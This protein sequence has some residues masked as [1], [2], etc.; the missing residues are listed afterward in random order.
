MPSE[1]ILVDERLGQLQTHLH[2]H[3]PRPAWWGLRCG[4]CRERWVRGA[5]PTKRDALVAIN[6]HRARMSST[7]ALPAGEAL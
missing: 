4:Y 3:V 6:A 7:T 1:T 2:L 5:C